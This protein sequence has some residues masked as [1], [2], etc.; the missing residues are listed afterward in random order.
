MTVLGKALKN[1]SLLSSMFSYLLYLYTFRKQEPLYLQALQ[2]KA[3][4]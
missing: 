2:S 3:M 1:I 4:V